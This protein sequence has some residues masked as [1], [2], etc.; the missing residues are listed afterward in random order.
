MQAEDEIA[1]I[2]V[3]I[4]GAF[5]GQ[6]GVTATS[7]PGVDLKAEALGLAV[8]LELPLILVDVQ[9]GGP[10]TGLPTRTEQADLML[11]MYGRHGEAPLPIVAA[12]SPSHCFDAAFEGVRLAVKYRTPVIV[13][14]DGYNANG[15]E[16][17]R[18]PDVDELPDISVPFTTEPNHL[19]EDGTTEFWPYVRDETTLARP[20]AIPGTPELM[21]RIG[22]IEKQDGTGNVNY[23]PENHELMTHLRAEKIARIANDIPLLAVDDPGDSAEVLVLGWGSTWGSIKA[24][25]RR[26]RA[27]GKPVATAQLFHLNPFPKNLGTVLAAYPKVLVP[28]M[29][30][31]QLSK[32]VRAEY[33]VDAQSLTKVQG[34]PFRAAEIEAKILEMIDG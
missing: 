1:A 9:R 8:S 32:L 34:L 27:A 15:S 5:T 28:E 17:W 18:F 13:L 10:S 29:N 12:Q 26:V 14:T 16:P 2:G 6:L 24:A 20:W 31:G 30:L 25:A 19:N 23:E 7:G 33:L 4:G 3:A 22:G 21:H 11:A